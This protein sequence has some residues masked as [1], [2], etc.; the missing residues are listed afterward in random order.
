MT[1]CFAPLM[2]AR[3]LDWSVDARAA[4]FACVVGTAAMLSWTHMLGLGDAVYDG[5]VG[6]IVSMTIVAITARR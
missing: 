4:I 1:T 5:A 6:F 3:C 2:I